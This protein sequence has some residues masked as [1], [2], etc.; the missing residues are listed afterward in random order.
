[1][2]KK[3]LE[4]GA[5]PAARDKLNNTVLHYAVKSVNKC[6]VNLV[7]RDE[8]VN[9]RNKYGET[10]LKILLSECAKW[11]IEKKRCYEVA[12]ILVDHSASLDAVGTSCRDPK[13]I[14]LLSRK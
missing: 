1:V 13:L 10:P 5:D 2:V 4:R 7:I 11:D 3:L 8:D 14:K 9:V 6:V 12:K